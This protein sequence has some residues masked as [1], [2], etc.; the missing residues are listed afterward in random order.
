VRRRINAKAKSFPFQALILANVK[1]SL[2][3]GDICD[4][5]ELAVKPD[6]EGGLPGR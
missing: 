3:I 5:R 2:T 4:I 1:L 6:E